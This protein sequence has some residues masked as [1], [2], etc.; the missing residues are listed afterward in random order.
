MKTQYVNI[1]KAKNCYKRNFDNQ[2]SRIKNKPETGSYVY[3][4]TD[5][6]GLRKIALETDGPCFVREMRNA[7]ELLK[8]SK[9]I[10]FV[11]LD[12]A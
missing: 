12:R 4:A 3:A 7:E 2:L 8:I 10:E 1:M 11:Y 6:S 9:N 5:N